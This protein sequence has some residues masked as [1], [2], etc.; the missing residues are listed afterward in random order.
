MNKFYALLLSA[1]TGLVGCSDKEEGIPANT[2]SMKIYDRTI[3]F[4]L[5]SAIVRKNCRYNESGCALY[6]STNDKDAQL[7]IGFSRKGSVEAPY[8][9]ERDSYLIPPAVVYTGVVKDYRSNCENY[10]G[11]I[12]RI[13]LNNLV[14]S[15]SSFRIEV[16][17]VDQDKQ[18]ISGKFSGTVCKYCDEQLITE[19]KFNVPYVVKP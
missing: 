13:S 15:S 7:S 9:Y 12:Q 10:T 2:F 8:V 16:E 3:D 5:D 19:G 17:K 11:S 1:S 6:G 4:T 14:C 18:I